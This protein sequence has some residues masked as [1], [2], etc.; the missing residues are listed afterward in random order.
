VE[1]KRAIVEIVGYGIV[2]ISSR[3][4]QVWHEDDDDESEKQGNADGRGV[5]ERTESE[6]V[7]KQPAEVSFFFF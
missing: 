4:K 3:A 1:C 5:A 6:S 7:G 2:A